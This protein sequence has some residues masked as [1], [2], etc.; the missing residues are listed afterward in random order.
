MVG[1]LP[2]KKSIICK[3]KRW[4]FFLSSIVTFITGVASVLIVRAF[5]SVFRKKVSVEKDQS[6]VFVGSERM[7]M[8][9]GLAGGR[10]VAFWLV[11]PT[12]QMQEGKRKGQSFQ[13]IYYLE[14]KQILG[15]SVSVK[16]QKSLIRFNRFRK[17]DKSS[18][19]IVGV[20][21]KVGLAVQQESMK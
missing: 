3:K 4:C 18:L 1:L 16:H 14:R 7:N 19:T 20:P 12:V 17:V 2:Y 8:G 11:A 5:N 10:T 15:K 9:K 6:D 13:L 21:S